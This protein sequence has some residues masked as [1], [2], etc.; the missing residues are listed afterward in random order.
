MFG[1][2]SEEEAIR[3]V[4]TGRSWAEFC[5]ML[6][7]AGNVL[8]GAPEDPQ[9]RAE[10]LRYLTRLTRAALQTF[11]E[12]ADPRAPVLQRV[13]HETAKIGND[14]PD[15]VYY[16]AAV[17]GAYR[18]RLSGTRG[19]VHWL[20]FATQKG[21][22]GEGRGMPPTGRLDG[23]DLTVDDD[24][25]FE[26]IL[27]VEDP[28]PGVDWLRME[29]ETGTL[30]V[31]Q[32]R[33]DPAT[34]TLPVLTLERIGGDGRPTP[35]HAVAIDEGLRRSAMLVGGASRIFTGWVEGFQEH[36]NA[37]PRFDQALSDQ[38]GGV[39]VIVY[40]HSYWRLADDEALVIESDPFPCD[41]WNFQLSNHWMESLD[42]RYDRIHTNSKLALPTPDG[43]IRIVVA[44]A[45]PGVPNW[46][47]T[48][49][50]RFGAM[51]FRWVRP[52]GDPPT[53]SCRVVQ[54]AELRG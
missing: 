36:V 2:P 50:H 41:H 21:Q 48:Q 15:N 5:D 10:G 51:C 35:P 29:P 43:R 18:Y 27:S 31:R 24:G 4:M 47:F 9:T 34:E 19:T 38:M 52:E 54:L 7:L 23:T 30:I 39:A 42:Y 40:H 22:Y 14:N 37:L 46:L 20:E 28:G 45:D 26:V 32:S 33:L 53:P 16:N 1:A 44:H 17:S 13:V 12:H 8:D 6:K 49:D 3:R 25:R 11:V